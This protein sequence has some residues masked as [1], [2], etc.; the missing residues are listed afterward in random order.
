MTDEK[1]PKHNNELV[2]MEE[3]SKIRPRIS[4]HDEAVTVVTCKFANG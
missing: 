4:C 1:V 3:R 2:L